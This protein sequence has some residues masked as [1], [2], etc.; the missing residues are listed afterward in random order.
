[1]ILG[2]HVSLQA[3]KQFL[4]SV[5]EALSYGAN[6]FMVYTGA[7]QNT[8]RK[9]LEELQ[10]EEAKAAMAK[11]NLS[12]DHVVVH[13]PY[14]VNLGNPDPEKRLFAVAFLSEEVRRTAALGSKILVLHPGAHMGDGPEEGIRRIADG[15]RNVLD[16][17]LETG[18]SIA[19]EGMAGKGTEVGRSFEEL[20]GLI[21]AV[22][23][24]HRIG[25]CLDT[26]HLNDAGYDVV[27]FDHL[28]DSFDEIVG[29]SKLLVL[30]VNDSKNP[31]GASKDRHENIGFGTLGFEV[32][33]A[34]IVNPRLKHI[35]KILETPYIDDP[36][37]EKLSYP[38]YRREI[39]M[40]RAATFDSELK[41][42]VLADRRR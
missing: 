26:C 20:A 15:L 41:A 21:R 17:T 5:E 28:L 16:H 7:P 33:H 27:D 42:N 6:A 32:L 18:V 24:E 1:M 14:I 12:F 2:C 22:G 11:A 37:N 3:P 4:G 10:I 23:N 13:A 30:H 38:P 40:I 31:R 25:V 19:L 29:L 9:P 34:A 39:A 36:A 8:F 35:P